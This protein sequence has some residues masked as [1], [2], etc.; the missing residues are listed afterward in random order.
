MADLVIERTA[1]GSAGEALSG[2]GTLL[3]GAQPV[4]GGDT[5]S[6]RLTDMADYA[7]RIWASVGPA[8]ADALSADGKQTA[9]A[10]EEFSRVDD[11]LAA[12]LT[13]NSAG[14]SVGVA[15]RG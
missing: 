9:A 15:G 13:G 6:A 1:F 11:A 2:A 7:R 12:G 14:G 8:L 10:G 3:A 4:P 5:G